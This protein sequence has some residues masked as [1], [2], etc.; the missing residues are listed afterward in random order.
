MES[1]R[2]RAPGSTAESP[3]ARVRVQLA[4]LRILL[5][6]ALVVASGSAQGCVELRPTS[7]SAFEF[8][9]PLSLAEA[10]KL[11]WTANQDVTIEYWARLDSPPAGYVP[12]VEICESTYPSIACSIISGDPV[13]FYCSWADGSSPAVAASDTLFTSLPSSQVTQWNHYAFV[14]TSS[15]DGTSRARIL[16]Y[17]NGAA[18]ADVTSS[19]TLPA[20]SGFASPG[21]R[22]NVH[23]AG[24]TGQIVGIAE[25]RVWNYARSASQIAQA[26]RW[27][28]RPASISLFPGLR[29]SAPLTEGP[30]GVSL[31]AAGLANDVD[32]APFADT[33][34]SGVTAQFYAAGPGADVC[35][36][37]ALEAAP[38]AL[39]SVEAGASITLHGGSI[40]IN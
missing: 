1:I 9:L 10:S 35:A 20:A 40:L 18:L 16:I 12:M 13:T 23:P 3:E 19:W 8:T 29:I 26:R 5:V 21:F 25:V 34:A 7:T 28:V 11:V 24:A 37:G 15:K 2:L 14:L 27:R 4:A 6:L 39:V 36:A 31:G 30:T 33:A 17:A 38:T 32:G 22:F